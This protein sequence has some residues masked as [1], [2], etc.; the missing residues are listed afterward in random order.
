MVA[1]ASNLLP[2]SFDTVI[3]PKAGFWRFRV[4]GW[5][6]AVGRRKLRRERSRQESGENKREEGSDSDSGSGR[7]AASG[8]VGSNGSYWRGR[9]V[10]G[11]AGEVD[12]RM[13]F[14]CNRC[15]PVLGAF[16]ADSLLFLKV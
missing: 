13:L 9:D 15:I 7:W 8:V 4:T 1:T 6:C 10:E 5:L 16:A 14:R 12:G 3:V 2:M 11:L